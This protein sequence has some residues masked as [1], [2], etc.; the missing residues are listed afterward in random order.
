MDEERAFLNAIWKRPK[1]LTARLVYADW[2]DENG[3]GWLADA[4]RYWASID[5]ADREILSSSRYRPSP[6]YCVGEL[7]R[8]TLREMAEQVKQNGKLSL[9]DAALVHLYQYAKLGRHK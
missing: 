4:V 2:L 5:P 7:H 6:R 8:K 1:E 3:H 9:P